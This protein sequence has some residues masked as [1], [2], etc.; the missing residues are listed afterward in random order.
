MEKH[1]LLS[2]RA[3][4]KISEKLEPEIV[5]PSLEVATQI[6]DMAYSKQTRLVQEVQ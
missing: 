1:C 6:L 3:V 2:I 5:G 4:M